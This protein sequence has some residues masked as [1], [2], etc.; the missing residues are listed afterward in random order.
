[1]EIR[2]LSLSTTIYIEIV[3]CLL[4]DTV[5]FKLCDGTVVKIPPWKCLATFFEDKVWYS[6]CWRRYQPRRPPW[7]S[8]SAVLSFKFGRK[9]ENMEWGPK[10]VQCW[11]KPHPG[12]VFCH[13]HKTIWRHVAM[14]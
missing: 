4:T 13:Y 2:H 3:T 14:I 8:R 11:R 10:L 9:E 6:S 12:R 1:L 7:W 5:V